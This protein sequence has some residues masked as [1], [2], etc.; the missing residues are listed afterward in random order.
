MHL[1]LPG[2]LTDLQFKDVPPEDEHL[3][4]TV[5]QLKIKFNDEN[6]VMSETDIQTFIDT[7]VKGHR[8]EFC[9]AIFFRLFIY[10][11]S[12]SSTNCSVVGNKFCK[13]FQ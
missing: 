1:E 5:N 13:S 12:V 10:S 2:I 7:M 11:L 4:Y 9:K 8:S 3:P 6:Y